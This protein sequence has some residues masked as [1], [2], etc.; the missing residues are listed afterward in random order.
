MKVNLPVSGLEKEFSDATTII[1]TTDLK[2]AVTSIN[3][4]FIEVSGFSEE[5][6]LGVNHNI[7]R[8]PDMPAAAFSDLWATLQGGN[9]WMGIV[10]NR[11]KNGDHYWV[12]AYAGCLE[13]EGGA[14]G[15]QSV[16]SK[17]RKEHVERAEALYQ[18]INDGRLG[19][20]AFKSIGLANRI[21]WAMVGLFVPVV[22]MFALFGSLPPI[23][24]VVATA[25]V[26]FGSYFLSRALAYPYVHAAK[27]SE[28]IINNPVARYIYSGRND[29][30]GQLQVALQMQQARMRTMVGRINTAAEQLT[31]V[32]SDTAAATQQTSNSLRQ[33]R[34]ETDQLATAITQMSA[35]VHEVAKNISQ[36]A[37]AASEADDEASKGTVIANNTISVIHELEG[38]VERAAQVI[39]KLEAE[40]LD[41]SKVLD[42][43]QG[44]AEQ[45]NLLAL[46]AAIEA[47]RAGEAG[48]GFAVVAD[49]VR[50]LASRTADSTKEINEMILKLQAGS[51]ESVGVMSEARAKAEEGVNQVVATTNSLQSIA[52]AVTVISDMNTQIATAAEEQ[53]AV[54]E[55]VDRSIHRISEGSEETTAASEQTAM[56]SKNL[57][58]MVKELRNTV[59]QCSH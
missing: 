15:Y 47:A 12:D 14:A 6:L 49:E 5:E 23:L 56:A 35:T 9:S 26:L 59:H 7:V 50:T 33:Q 18:R 53:S 42:V 44:V 8:H 31:D 58:A 41:I 30:L 29:E 46:N 39:Q 27:K 34:S 4:G 28:S 52:N 54:A 20:R 13:G 1:S 21:W 57:A 16:R 17:P 40:A 51:K 11:C 22:V 32:S 10:K 19:K 37:Q 55:E 24:S 38:D 25:T 3:S 48:R 45:T 43:I 36:A 2:G